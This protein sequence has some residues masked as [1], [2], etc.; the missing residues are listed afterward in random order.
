MVALTPIRLTSPA[1]TRAQKRLDRM[2]VMSAALGLF[3]DRKANLTRRSQIYAGMRF[4][5]EEAAFCLAEVKA[6]LAFVKHM[7][8]IED[9]RARRD[10]AVVAAM[11]PAERAARIGEIQS[12]LRT[13]DYLPLGISAADR[14]REL[15]DELKSLRSSPLPSRERARELRFPPL[16][17]ALPGRCNLLPESKLRAVR[18]SAADL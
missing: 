6:K 17:T 10:R 7:E 8:H 13:L 3:R 1:R 9:E 2:A 16:Q 15:E 4:A 5:G 14:A 11:T 12:A 18:R